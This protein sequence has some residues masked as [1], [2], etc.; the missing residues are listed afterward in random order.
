[1]QIW[2]L[3]IDDSGKVEPNCLCDLNRHQNSV[4]VVRWSP[5]GRL[6]ASGDTGEKLSRGPAVTAA[7]FARF[8]FTYLLCQ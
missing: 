4:N 8:Q 5:N 6:L 2:E 3:I 7:E 1:M